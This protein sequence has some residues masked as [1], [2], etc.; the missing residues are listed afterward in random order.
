MRASLR[1]FAL[2]ALAT[3][4][5]GEDPKPLTGQA[6]WSDACPMSACPSSTHSVRGS[7]GAPTTDVDCSI[8]PSGGGYQVFFRVASLAQA[9]QN[10]DDSTEGLLASG[11]LPAVGQEI[12]TNEAGGYVRIQGLGWRISN[13]TIGPSTG[14]CHVFID[15]LATGGFSGRISCTGS[16]EGTGV[17]DDRTP[18]TRRIIRGGVTAM[19]PD[20]GEFVFT[21][22]GTSGG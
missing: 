9:G 18:P 4:A 7:Q 19:S 13:A 8:V 16:P 21:N 11:F 12:R 5:C 22:C 14:A 6:S 10:F 15:R 17:P 2:L 3:S 1:C 20:F